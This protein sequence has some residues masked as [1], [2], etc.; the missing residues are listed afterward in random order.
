MY[1]KYI[2]FGTEDSGFRSRQTPSILKNNIK[3]RL[4]SVQAKSFRWFLIYFNA[5]KCLE[6]SKMITWLH[7]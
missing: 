3:K 7:G 6:K 5:P 2:T 4:L 1:I